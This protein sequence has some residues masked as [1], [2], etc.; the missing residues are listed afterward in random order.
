ME[1]LRPALSVL[2]YLVLHFV[3]RQSRLR[4]L[5]GPVLFSCLLF[6]CRHSR[7]GPGSGFHPSLNC[8]TRPGPIYASSRCSFS[9]R[10]FWVFCSIIYM[11][12]LDNVPLGHCPMSGF[13]W[14]RPDES[15]CNFTLHWVP[16]EGALSAAPLTCV[17]PAPVTLAS[18]KS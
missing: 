16:Q 15:R 2:S 14:S 10:L 8:S 6:Y 4:L 17:T 9:P 7:I 11:P 1:H 12:C 13:A 3:P 18:V 5:M